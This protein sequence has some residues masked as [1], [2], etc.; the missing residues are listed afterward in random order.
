MALPLREW[1]SRAPAPIGTDDFPGAITKVWLARMARTE[2]EMS[3]L[4]SLLNPAEQVR[5]DQFKA[6]HP[7]HQFIFGRAVLR[8]ILG[9]CLNVAPSVVA[10]GYHPAGK[11]F[12]WQPVSEPQLH[13]NLSHS[14][15]LIL[16]AVSRGLEVGVDL[17]WIHGVEDCASLEPRIFSARERAELHA[18]PQAHQRTACFNGWTRKEAWLK[19]TGQGL[20]DHLGEIEVTIA[21]G[22]EPQFLSLPGGPQTLPRWTLHALALPVDYAGALVVQTSLV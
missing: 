22:R 11:P 4:T 19:A 15:D 5:A 1:D 3:Q 18:L 7:R 10:F 12:L 14:K 20:V 21:P 13:F 17:E 16:V 2:G 6:E 9:A 8:Q